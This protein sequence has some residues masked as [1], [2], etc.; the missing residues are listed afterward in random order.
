M[1]PKI[2]FLLFC[3][4]GFPQIFSQ[5][6]TGSSYELGVG[7]VSQQALKLYCENGIGVDF[8]GDFLLNRHLHVKLSYV[9]SRLGSA[10]GS[11]AIK[12][13]S[14]L[15]GLDWRFR[16]EK[17]FQLFAG[18]STGYFMA[19]Y[20]ESIFN[21][22]PSKSVMIA[23]E[24]GLIYKFQI[25]VSVGLTGGYNVINGNGINVPGTLFP[26][27]GRLS[28]MYDLSKLFSK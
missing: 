4:T 16:T 23:P 14:Y 3:F 28:V 7:I 22:L 1:K 25:P 20:E 12:Q 10:L 2:L 24:F 13:D 21:S 26:I 19:D 15:F 9:T 8:A 27:Y 11:N 5:N 6:N 18:I 17:A